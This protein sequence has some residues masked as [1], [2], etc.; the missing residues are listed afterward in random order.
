MDDL[1]IRV[2]NLDVRLLERAVAVINLRDLHVVD[3]NVGADVCRRQSA[4]GG[5]LCAPI[6]EDMIPEGARNVKQAGELTGTTENVTVVGQ[7]VY[8]YG[9]NYNGNA[10]IDSIIL[11]DV[12]DGEIYG[13]QVY[14]YTNYTKYVVGDVVKVTGKVELYGGVP[15]MK[16]PAMTVVKAGLKPI[17][18]QEITVSQMGKE[19]LSEYVFIKDITLG[20]YNKDGNTSVTDKTGTKNLFKGVPLPANT[21]EADVIALYACCSAF[22]GN[23]QL[24]NGSSTDYVTSLAPAPSGELPKDGDKVVIYNQNAKAVL[25]EQIGTESPSI[26]K[27]AAEIA[28]GKAVPANGAVVFEVEQNGEYLRFKNETYGYLCS[29]GTGNNAFYCKTFDDSI[30]TEDADWL[31]RTCSGGVDREGQRILCALKG[32]QRRAEH[33]LRVV[34]NAIVELHA[35]CRAPKRRKISAR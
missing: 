9:K 21:Q 17:A 30:K 24:R 12:I 6:T 18:A 33:D 14:D 13:F 20:T 16:F 10:S 1:S 27:A 32:V 26:N 11:E 35:L 29:N 3:G 34:D 31:V 7:V 19:Y 25:A 22:N 8:H 2:L 15:Q 4:D 5:F 28:D 23:Y